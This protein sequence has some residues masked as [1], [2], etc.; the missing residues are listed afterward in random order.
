MYE[1]VITTNWPGAPDSCHVKQRTLS[2]QPHPFPP[3]PPYFFF[4]VFLVRRNQHAWCYS[5]HELQ[6][7]TTTTE[8]VFGRGFVELFIACCQRWNFSLCGSATAGIRIRAPSGPTPPP[9]ASRLLLVLVL[10]EKST[11][12]HQD[13]LDAI[14]TDGKQK[15]KQNGLGV[16]SQYK[17][18]RCHCAAP[19]NGIIT[20]RQVAENPR[21]PRR[22]GAWRHRDK[23]C[24]VCVH[25]ILL[26]FLVEQTAAAAVACEQ[27]TLV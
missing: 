1:Y 9:G 14:L 23:G 20:S 2:T 11:E 5:S 13:T 24:C 26:D 18:L 15:K 25:G 16:L 7:N 3:P 21:R 19:G 8:I 22:R 6:H 12:Q 4:T 10:Y 17:S 27:L